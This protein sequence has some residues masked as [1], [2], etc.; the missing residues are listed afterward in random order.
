MVI[1][2]NMYLKL[3]LHYNY[4]R[5]QVLCEWNLLKCHFQDTSAEQSKRQFFFILIYT[6]FLICYWFISISVADNVDY[7]IFPMYPYPLLSDLPKTYPIDD[8]LLEG[9]FFFF[10][11]TE[12]HKYCIYKGFLLNYKSVWLWKQ[13]LISSFNL[14]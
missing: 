9:I 1:I 7:W 8:F 14:S 6:F 3:M 2:R 5:N 13:A 11:P 12:C 4:G 10:F